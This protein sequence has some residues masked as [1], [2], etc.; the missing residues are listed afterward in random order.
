[1]ED[2]NLENVDLYISNSISDYIPNEKSFTFTARKELA[3]KNHREQK[4]SELRNSLVHELNI[5]TINSYKHQIEN[6]IAMLDLMAKNDID[7]DIIEYHSYNLIS[8]EELIELNEFKA[9][10]VFFDSI[11][12]KRP[13][14]GY[15]YKKDKDYLMKKVKRLILD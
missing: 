8:D 2:N 15:S 5:E 10:I 7:F 1:M 9:E 11:N 6:R 12:L 4:I 3:L 13:Q 14:G